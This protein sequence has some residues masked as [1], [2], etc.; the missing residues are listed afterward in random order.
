MSNEKEKRKRRIM[1]K[2]AKIRDQRKRTR[3]RKK[4]MRQPR[5]DEVYFEGLK[6]LDS[7]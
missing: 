2:L 7:L 6:W 1:A 5:Y 3:R 4:P